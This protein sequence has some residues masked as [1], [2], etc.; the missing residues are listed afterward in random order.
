MKK[1]LLQWN[2]KNHGLIV[3]LQAVEAL[4][5]KNCVVEVVYL[6]Q[7]SDLDK[8]Q[9]IELEVYEEEKKS[10]QQYKNDFDEKEFDRIEKV[11]N[12]KII[13]DDKKVQPQIIQKRLHLKSVTDYQSIYNEVRKFLK[14][15]QKKLYLHINVSP[16]TPQMHTIWL[17][18]NASGY[19]P[20]G[21]QIWSSQIDKTKE[22]YYFEEIKFRPQ[23]YLNELFESSYQRSHAIKIN[24]NDTINGKR[25]QAEEQLRLFVAIQDAPILLIGERGVGKTTYVEQIIRNEFYNELPYEELPC[26]IF[27]EELMRSELFGYEQGAFTGANTKKEGIL[28]TF[29]NGGL[30]FLD[31]IHDLS[32]PLQRQLMQVL[33]SGEF[34]PI[35]S[36]KSVK[37]QFRLVTATNLQFAQLCKELTPDF[38]DR[39][40]RFV[41]EIPPIRDCPEDIFRYWEDT[42]NSI[43]QEKVPQSKS[44]KQFLKSHSFKGNFRDLQR[45]AS[46][47]SAFS[48]K[49]EE[50][51]A[52]KQAIKTTQRWDIEQYT[53]N[54]RYFE[55]EQTYNEIVNFFNKD[56][57]EWAIAEY[58]SRKKAAQILGKSESWI[59]N[60]FNG[61]SRIN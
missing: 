13:L 41:V 20:S 39:I 28:S 49:N 47:L 46:Y 14:N 11:F 1:V 36:T 54:H 12:K 29:K 30:L 9:M 24:P 60:A 40:A 26:G 38:L 48:K 5:E 33:Q 31:E 19:L 43:T 56:L 3:A 6:L 25:K 22:K 10:I 59:S 45:F 27:S 55:H 8:V 52:I 23:T 7:S 50:E 4:F 18:L 57:V 58:G 42:W 17:M 15:I 35:G 16:G 53:T 21:T 2:S 61:K 51:E 37:A 32:K 44:I 34:R